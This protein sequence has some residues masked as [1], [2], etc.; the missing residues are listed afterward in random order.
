[1]VDK[2][3]ELWYNILCIIILYQ[4]DTIVSDPP[5]KLM[6]RYRYMMKKQYMTDQQIYKS[7]QK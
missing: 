6:I 1:M 7:I 5:E 2:Y 4:E 3:T